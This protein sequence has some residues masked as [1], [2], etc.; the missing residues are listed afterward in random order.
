MNTKAAI[1]V[2]SLAKAFGE[3]IALRGLDL[4][5]PEGTVFGLLGRNG[6][7]KTTLLR[8]IMGLLRPDEGTARVFGQDLGQA[9]IELRSR[10]AYVPQEARLFGRLS[11][12]K[13]AQLLSHFYP[14]FDQA[15]ARDLAGRLDVDW[16]QSFGGLSLG[17]KRKAAVVL[18]LSSGADLLVLDEP[19]AGLDP[20]AR[21]E[22]YTLLVDRLGDGGE[23]TV[24]LSTHLVGDL[25]RLADRVAI[26]DGG[27]TLRVDDVE[28]LSQGYERVQVIFPGAVPN[29]FELPGAYTTT[30]DGSVVSG[31][32]ELDKACAGLTTLES[33]QDLRVSRF[34]LHLEEVF[35]ELV[36]NP[37]SVSR[38]RRS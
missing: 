8:T 32:V 6:A 15:E 3:K 13:H 31:I 11:L 24:L 26:I 25:E 17:N 37:T 29:D 30:R 16:K 20:I 2:Q 28:N 27:R 34:P 7:G 18:A 33:R 21:R 22:L 1:Q 19:A 5:I 38:G 10:V 14:L 23:V 12:Q 36:G 4:E 35:I 9:G